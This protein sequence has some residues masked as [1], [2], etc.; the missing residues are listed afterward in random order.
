[1]PGSTLESEAAKKYA[2]L[3]AGDTTASDAVDGKKKNREKAA[4]EWLNHYLAVAKYVAQAKE[5]GVV[6]T[7]EAE[8]IA[9][10]VSQWEGTASDKDEAISALFTQIPVAA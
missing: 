8:L 5:D 1:M 10:I 2:A 4:K 7:S 9:Y 6:I 3:S